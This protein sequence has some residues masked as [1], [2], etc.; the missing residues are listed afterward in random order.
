MAPS[1]HR[2]PV[3]TSYSIHYTKLY[4]KW[5][6][7]FID[8]D[9]DPNKQGFDKFYGYNCQT[10]AHNYFPGHLWDNHTEV[11]LAGNVDDQFEEYSPDLIH[12][13]ALKFLRNN[14][15]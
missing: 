1:K 3:I 10:L 7:G 12:K 15:V 9:G 8:S 2:M 11:E 4:E 13:E 6:L 5:G 14:F